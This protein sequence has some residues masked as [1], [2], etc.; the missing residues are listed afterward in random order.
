VATSKRDNPFLLPKRDGSAKY[1]GEFSRKKLKQWVDRMPVSDVQKLASDLYEKLDRLNATDISSASRFEILELLQPSVNYLLDSLKDKCTEGTFPLDIERRMVAGLR[2]GILV[3]VVM[4]YKTVLSQLH[5]ATVT[6]T[7]FHRQTKAAA[8]REAVFYLGEVLLHSYSVYQPCVNYA[9]KELHGIYYYAVQNKLNADADIEAK[10]DKLGQLGVDGLYKQIALLALV[11]PRSLLKGEAERVNTI[12]RELVAYVDLEPIGRAASAESYYIIDAQSDEMPCAPNLQKESKVNVG[13]CLVTDGLRKIMDRKISSAEA[14]LSSMRPIDAEVLRLMRK[15]RDSWSNQIR[16]RELRNQIT[17]EVELI[18]G[19]D[20]MY[21]VHGGE[22]PSDTD[23]WRQQLNMALHTSGYHAIGSPI[24]DNEEVL[25][26]I[27]PGTL[28]PYQFN[29][30]AAWQRPKRDQIEVDG[31]ECIALNRSEH[32]YCL[33]WP[34]SGDGGTHVGELVGINS[35]GRNGGISEASL[36]VIRWLYADQP[37]FLDMGIELLNG[38]FEPIILQC[39]RE[40]KQ[41]VEKIKGFLQHPDSGYAASLITPPFYVT[42]K[43]HV[44]VIT[45][46]EDIPVNVTNIIES[47][48]SFVRFGFEQV[49]DSVVIM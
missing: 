24:L 45:G 30:V 31:K 44:R 7:I 40:N 42:E 38:Y 13:W 21:Q 8:L 11:N 6:A 16:P 23:S 29:K 48:D 39:E 28:E 19:L 14:S 41:R 1:K 25:I 12:L 36:G 15:L 22:E 27:K 5:D 17:D 34:D 46:N 4:G 2:L 33:N 32:G 47:T 37:G 9:W 35:K 26:E 49:S 3:Q 20:S 18:C 43:D 10:Q